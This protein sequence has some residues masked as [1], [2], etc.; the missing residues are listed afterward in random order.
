MR[1]SPPMPMP[2]TCC[3]FRCRRGSELD[4]LGEN[5]LAFF[6]TEVADGV[7]DPVERG[8]EI[9]FG[10]PASALHAFEERIELLAAP[11]DDADADEDLG[12]QAALG[13]K[14]FDQPVGDEL[15]VLG[16]AQALG[17][18]LEGQ[19]EAG[20]ILVVVERGGLGDGERAMRVGQR[21]VAVAGPRKRRVVLLAELA[22]GQ[23]I[24][25][26]FKM[27]VQLGLGQAGD[28]VGG[29]GIILLKFIFDKWIHQHLK[30]CL[31]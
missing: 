13:G 4:G 21:L 8:A 27:K 26:A 14:L 22:E 28:E 6:G 25:G 7:E 16:I 29:H 20:E 3:W 24:D 18:R 31:L 2:M 19:E 23:R 9:F 17:D 12:V 10:A 11:E 1:S 5:L 30:S 15:E